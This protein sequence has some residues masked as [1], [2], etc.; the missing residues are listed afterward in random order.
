MLSHIEKAN[1]L[2]KIIFGGKKEREIAGIKL[3]SMNLGFACML[4]TVCRSGHCLKKGMRKANTEKCSEGKYAR[5][6]FFWQENG[7][8]VI[9]GIRERSDLNRKE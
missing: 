6:F 8:C 4:S 2:I 7:N 5:F 3:F 1:K 9:F